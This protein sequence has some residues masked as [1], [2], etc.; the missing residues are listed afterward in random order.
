MLDRYLQP[1]PI[2]VPGELYVGGPALARGYVN[3]PELTA[4][5]F[6]AHPWSRAGAILF[7]TGDRARLLDDGAVEY[8]GRLDRQVKL[9]GFRIE[10]GEIEAA[11]EQHPHV[12]R[13][14]VEASDSRNGELRL[15]AYLVERDA[16]SDGGLR[17]HLRQRLRPGCCWLLLSASP[18]CR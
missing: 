1:A 6:V 3:R 11:I 9:R 16:V 13:A 14:A 7:R 15:A 4:E 17:D 2:G 12:L 10:P 18:R 8:F 5:R